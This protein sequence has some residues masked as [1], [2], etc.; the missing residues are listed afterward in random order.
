MEVLVIFVVLLIVFILLGIATIPV[1]AGIAIV[2]KIRNK[3]QKEQQYMSTPPP[4]LSSPN[5]NISPK[6]R[7]IMYKVLTIFLLVIALLLP[8]GLIYGVVADRQ[9][10]SLWVKNE[11][12]HSWG[13]KQTIA[14]PLLVIPYVYNGHNSY[15]YV[16]P[17]DYKSEHQLKPEEHYRGIFKNIVY[18]DKS[19]SSGEFNLNA[20]NSLGIP[21]ESL[22][23]DNA[24]VLLGLTQPRSIASNPVLKIAG[25]TPELLSGTNGAAILKEGLYAPIALTNQNSNIPFT[26][27]LALNGSERLFVVPVG[28][29]NR[30]M[31]QSTWRKPSFNGDISPSTR[32]INEKG[33]TATW[34]IP[35]FGRN[36]PQVFTSGGTDIK[37]LL[38]ETT[39]GVS[40]LSPVDAY[41]QTIRAIKY[42]ALFLV[43]TFATYFLFEVVTKQKLH[44]FQYTL[45]GCALCL[46]YLL[47]IALSEIIDFMLAYIIASMA[48][49]TVITL[50]S[51]AI[52]GR[53]K[54]NAQFIIGSFLSL[55]Y[56]F[57]Y[58]L[59]QLEDFS[60]LIGT[61]GLFVVLGTLM[62]CTRNI[63]WFSE[64][65]A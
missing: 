31:M 1:L 64:Q 12:A 35:S 22:R 23:F 15:A 33:F 38:S 6:S 21:K 60:L 4:T 42:G 52:I 34:D 7:P 59:L 2:Q 29:H 11:M 62:Y 65:T 39:I 53:V 36:L 49:V 57:L 10:R 28:K 63:N 50:Y 26:L 18:T 40:L 56:S 16:M 48:I 58:V 43:L 47:L 51:Q 24:F 46:F 55:L 8:L 45:I 27:D 13:D 44:P 54:K 61:L 5:N 25:K 9:D 14:G 41:Q 17:S 30:V 37:D 32:T 20:L 3:K 19:T